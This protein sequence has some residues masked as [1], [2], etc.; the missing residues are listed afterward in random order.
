MKRVGVIVVS[1]VLFTL[2]VISSCID[3]NDV[4]TKYIAVKDGTY[5]TGTD[6]VDIYITITSGELVSVCKNTI[7]K[8]NNQLDKMNVKFFDYTDLGSQ[9][10]DEYFHNIADNS[11]KYKCIV[12]ETA[13]NQGDTNAKYW[14]ILYAKE[15]DCWYDCE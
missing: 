3:S 8:S 10:A 11:N 6:S 4:T 5:V 13:Y 14:V 7:N 15:H 12:K 2:F 9:L 1:I